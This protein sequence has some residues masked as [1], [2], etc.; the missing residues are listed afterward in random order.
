MCM[1][2]N[3]VASF[4]R[5]RKR[6]LSVQDRRMQELL[7]VVSEE[8]PGDPNIAFTKV[9][10]DLLYKS[11]DILR[12]LPPTGRDGGLM[13]KV[14]AAHNV[15]RQYVYQVLFPE[16]PKKLFC[17]K[18]S[19]HKAIWLT[20]HN[21]VSNH[22]AAKLYCQL[23]NE[24]RASGETTAKIPKAKIRFIRKRAQQLA[25]NAGKRLVTEQDTKTIPTTYVFKLV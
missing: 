17:G 9:E 19:T 12:D 8:E 15:T 22:S 14:A 13:Q 21:R 10:K 2:K 3:L 5:K 11:R 18:T 23:F 7:R 20:M 6:K 24:L 25:D 16:E 4:S 1:L